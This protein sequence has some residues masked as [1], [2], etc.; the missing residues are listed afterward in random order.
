VYQRGSLLDGLAIY[1]SCDT[2]KFHD[3][4]S[5][6]ILHNFWTS[7][8]RGEA[9]PPWRRHC[10]TTLR[11]SHPMYRKTAKTESDA[12]LCHLMLV[13]TICLLEKIP[14]CIPPAVQFVFSI[15]TDAAIIDGRRRMLSAP[16]VRTSG[17]RGQR[18]LK[19]IHGGVFV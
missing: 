12:M 6:H 16:V 14:G 11:Q 8:H 5:I 17:S 19:S 13:F 4:E 15:A 7:T 3:N 18:S 10:R 2:K 1:L 9:S